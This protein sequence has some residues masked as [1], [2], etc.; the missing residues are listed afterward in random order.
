MH[1]ERS[2]AILSGA[3]SKDAIPI[4]LPIGN[5]TLRLRPPSFDFAQDA[6]GSAQG[7]GGF[8]KY[9]PARGSVK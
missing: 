9:H 6:W 3:Q 8:L 5:R 7:A 4:Q 2:P 1:P